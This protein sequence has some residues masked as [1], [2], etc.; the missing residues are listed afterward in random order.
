M[1]ASLSLTILLLILGNSAYATLLT[2]LY[3]RATTPT[4]ELYL[5][6]GAETLNLGYVYLILAHG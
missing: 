6:F 3:C 1:A 4:G 2:L 5:F